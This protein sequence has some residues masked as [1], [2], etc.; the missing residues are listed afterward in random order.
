MS[1]WTLR[2]LVRKAAIKPSGLKYVLLELAHIQGANPHA[3]ASVPHLAALTGMGESTVKAHTKTAADR[4][5]LDKKQRWN[6][7]SLYSLRVEA[8]RALPRI[9]DRDSQNPDIQIS[10]GNTHTSTT[11]Q[12]PSSRIRGQEQAQC[13]SDT[14]EGLTWDQVDRFPPVAE[15]SPEDIPD[16]AGPE[17]TQLAQRS[18]P[19]F[20]PVTSRPSPVREATDEASRQYTTW[21]CGSPEGCPCNGDPAKLGYCPRS[22][23]VP[24]EL[25]HNGHLK[26][27]GQV[28]DNV[29][30]FK[31]PA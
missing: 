7:T 16:W 23:E 12:N 24:A 22:V 14:I 10:D 20:T 30:P 5:L 27:I 31:R 15:S 6:D 18:V 11:S 4:G 13:E 21:V 1:A 26:P 8:L 19:D 2:D 29:R 17:A 25:D 3:W 9:R 28:P